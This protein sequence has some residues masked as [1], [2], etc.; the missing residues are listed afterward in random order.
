MNVIH[1]Q[2]YNQN[3]MISLVNLSSRILFKNSIKNIILCKYR[4]S[5]VRLI[6]TSDKKKENTVSYYPGL[7]EKQPKGPETPKDF[8]DV[9]SQKVKFNYE[10]NFLFL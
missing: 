10:L 2:T 5:V 3:K 6:S 7:M 8:A 9:E 1:E 4:P